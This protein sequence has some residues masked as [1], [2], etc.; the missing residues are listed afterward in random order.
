MNNQN[1]SPRATQQ[2]PTMKM[3]ECDDDDDDD[4]DNQDNH[5][6]YTFCR[7][8]TRLYWVHTEQFGRKL[9]QKLSF[10]QQA[11]IIHL[12][13]NQNCNHQHHVNYPPPHH[14]YYLSR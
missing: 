14:D 6:E 11:L 3:I 9:C 5:D 7:S 1:L 2:G 10:S 8:E 13:Y 4:D 12:D